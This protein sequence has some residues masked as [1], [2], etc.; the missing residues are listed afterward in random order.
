MHIQAT[1]RFNYTLKIR[2]RLH[3]VTKRGIYY[4]KV[5]SFRLKNEGATYQQLVNKM[6]VEYLSNIMEV[7]INNMLVKSL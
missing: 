1:T 2:R 7:Y 5:M 6:F 3:F 4:Y